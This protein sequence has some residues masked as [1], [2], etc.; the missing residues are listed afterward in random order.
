M[1]I[2]GYICILCEALYH[3]KKVMLQHQ[4]RGSFAK[5]N[6]HAKV[7]PNLTAQV[8]LYFGVISLLISVLYIILNRTQ[9]DVIMSSWLPFM[10]GGVILI[11]ISQVMKSAGSSSHDLS[12]RKK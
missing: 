1:K 9:A 2:I 12:K 6:Q 7:K 3:K 8:I 5:R 10:I 11:V 4:K